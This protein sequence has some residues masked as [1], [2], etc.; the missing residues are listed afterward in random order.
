M[1][2]E[3]NKEIKKP[4]AKELLEKEERLNFFR[5]EKEVQE[6]KELTPEEKFIEEEIQKE[7]EMMNTDENLRQQAEAKAQKIQVLDEDDKIKHLL[8]LAQQKGVA[9]AIN[10]AKKMND[11]YI[12]DIL[13]DVLAREGLYKKFTK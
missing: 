1:A 13:H 9:F 11:P 4:T 5:E 6:E 7:I 3:K 2:E 8:S 10:V 12:L